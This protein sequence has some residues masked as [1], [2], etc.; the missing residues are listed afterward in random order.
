MLTA[1]LTVLLSGCDPAENTAATGRAGGDAPTFAGD[2]GPTK[3]GCRK[4]GEAIGHWLPTFDRSLKEEATIK[5]VTTNPCPPFVELISQIDT[6]IPE[7]ERRSGSVAKQFAVGVK[8]FAGRYLAAA[9][10][11]KCLYEA[12]QLTIGIY[13]HSDHPLSVGV[14]VAV[15]LDLAADLATCYVFGQPL[16]TT[17]TQIQPPDGP[18]PTFCV[19]STLPERDGRRTAVIAFGT[20]TWMCDALGRAV[21]ND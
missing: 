2:K 13:R 12:D 21:P 16:R 20:S 6:L 10:T 19:L 9:D 4:P 18:E 1:L 17:P 5:T 15:G 3:A 7:G 11:A 8:G 14:V